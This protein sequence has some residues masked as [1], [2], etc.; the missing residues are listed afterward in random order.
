MYNRGPRTNGCHTTWKDRYT[1]MQMHKTHSFQI[2]KSQLEL[3]V[4]LKSKVDELLQARYTSL[5]VENFTRVH[6]SEFYLL[7]PYQILTEMIRQKSFHASS[8]CMYGEW[9]LAILKY[10]QSILFFLKTCLL[11]EIL[12]LTLTYLEEGK[13]PTPSYSS[14]PVCLKERRRM[15]IEGT[16]SLKD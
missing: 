3:V 8:V 12:Y 1:D 13:A 2:Q 6:I 10:T 14:H 4:G 5:K 15:R 11:G 7:R 16:G 9:N